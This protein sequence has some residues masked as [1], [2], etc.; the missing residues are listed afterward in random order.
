MYYI[1]WRLT[2]WASFASSLVCFFLGMMC[3]VLREKINNI[4]NKYMITKF[5]IEHWDEKCNVLSKLAIQPPFWTCTDISSRLINI[6]FWRSTRWDRS[7]GR[8]RNYT[9][10]KKR[11]PVI[12]ERDTFKHKYDFCRRSPMP[13][14]TYM[15]DY[16]NIYILILYI[17]IYIHLFIFFIHTCSK[18]ILF[19]DTYFPA[20]RHSSNQRFLLMFMALLIFI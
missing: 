14:G 11:I 1:L 10:N 19:I 6:S 8:R 7:Q 17:Y 13:R 5:Q 9:N 3:L 12:G 16:I 15:Y 20:I 2:S 18:L 4:I